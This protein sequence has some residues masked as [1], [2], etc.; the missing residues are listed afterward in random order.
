[1]PRIDIVDLLHLLRPVRRGKP[2]GC[3]KRTAE[4]KRL[5]AEC[6]ALRKDAER[7]RLVSRLELGAKG[8]AICEWVNTGG[9]FRTGKLM[10]Q[11]IDATLDAA[12]TKGGMKDAD[13]LRD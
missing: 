3:D 5:R 2:R 6:D 13:Q 11:E 9:W 8:F 7:Y 1:M 12:L 10:P 4:I